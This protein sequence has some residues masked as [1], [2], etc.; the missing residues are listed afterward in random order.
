VSPEARAVVFDLDDTLYPFRRFLRSGFAAAA[1]HLSRLTG[2][3]RRHAFR[4]LV[5]AARR[6]ARGIEV[7]T[8]LAALGLPARHTG[9]L[10]RVIQNHHPRLRLPRSSARA[11]ACLRAGGWRLGIL[12]NGPRALQLRKISALGLAGAV[13]AVVF[14]T[15]HGHGGGKPDPAPFAAIARELGVRPQRTVVVGDDE[16]CD[17]TGALGAG[18]I[19]IRCTAWAR[20]LPGTAAPAAASRI[21]AVPSIV[22]A[23]MREKGAQHAA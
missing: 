21:D 13:D 9:E 1:W 17:V 23:L 16:V 4:L 18:M 15:E 3:D 22:A 14:A 20:G 11:V 7:Q 8:C 12:T 6:G 19:P 10:V 2:A 5:S